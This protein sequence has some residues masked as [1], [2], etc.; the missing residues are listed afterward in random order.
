MYFLNLK[1][2]L[3]TDQIQYSP[4]QNI[5]TLG[6]GVSELRETYLKRT[7]FSLLPIVVIQFSPSSTVFTFPGQVSLGGPLFPLHSLVSCEQTGRKHIAAL[8]STFDH[9]DLETPC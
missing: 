3:F 8:W 7:S 2:A 6:R 1:K 4:N 9:D 5:Y